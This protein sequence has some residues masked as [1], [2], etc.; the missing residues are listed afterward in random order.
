MGSIHTL[1]S[2][3][4]EKNIQKLSLVWLDD[5]MK[6]TN[7]YEHFQE[8]L[9]P[10]I[11]Q[12]ESFKDLH[13]CKKYLKSL[14]LEDQIVFLV[15]N[16]LGEKIIERI[17]R[18]RQVYSIYIHITNEMKNEQWTHKFQKVNKYS[19]EDLKICLILDQRCFQ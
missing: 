1:L 18:Y 19:F 16:E 2:K 15:N 12:I 11:N 3:G 10:M 17:H 5:S 14:S 4:E 7:Q 6:E 13:Q 9:R 8:K